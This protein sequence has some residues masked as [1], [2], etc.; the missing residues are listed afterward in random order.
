MDQRL[1]KILMRQQAAGFPDLRGAEASLTLP[2]SDRLLNEIL[3]EGVTLPAQVRELR[4]HAHA[5]NR[6]GVRVKVGASF[7]PAINLTLVIDRQPELPASPVL[8]LKLELGGLLSL[9]GPALR[10]LDALPPGIRVDRD[11]IY[12][13]LAK[14]A[15]QRGLESWLAYLDLLHVETAEGSLVVTLRAAVR[16]TNGS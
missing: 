15:E 4:V 10:F 14:L 16:N 11:R 13:D 6:I 3:S 12:V 2:I 1:Q 9:A 5:G 7:L 8:G